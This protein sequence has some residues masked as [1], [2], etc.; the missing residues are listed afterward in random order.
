MGSRKVFSPLRT[1]PSL[2]NPHERSGRT[3]KDDHCSQLLIDRFIALRYRLRVLDICGLARQA[4]LDPRGMLGTPQRRANTADSGAVHR[5]P[6]LLKHFG[7]LGIPP[8]TAV[9]GAEVPPHGPRRR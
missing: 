4:V 3:I 8:V 7:A 9:V 5:G 6:P 2:L 1:L